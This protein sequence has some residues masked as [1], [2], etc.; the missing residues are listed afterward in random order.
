MGMKTGSLFSGILGAEVAAD[1]VDGLRGVW[2]SEIEPWCC[3]VIANRRPDLPNLGDVREINGRRIEP[4]DVVTFGSPCQDLSVAGRRAGLD[5]ARSS[6][7]FE[8]ARVI[9]QCRPAFAIWENVPGAFSSN[10]GRDFWSVLYTLRELGANDVAWR[11]YDSQYAGVPQQRRRIYLVAD[12]RG[13]RAGEVLFDANRCGGHPA[14]LPAPGQGVAGTLTSGTSRLGVNR[15]GRRREDDYNLTL[16]DVE[17]GGRWLP[18]EGTPDL[19]KPLGSNATGGFR[20]DLDHDTYVVAPAVTSKWAKG[21]GG[22]ADDETQNLTLIQDVRG[23]AHKRQNGAGIREGETAYT[24]DTVS[25]QAVAFEPRHFTRGKA[26]PPADLV[27]ALT[28]DADRGDG[29]PLV[30]ESRFARNGRGAPRE[31]VPTLK[32]ESGQTGRGDGAALMQHHGTIRRFTPVECEMLQGFPPGWTCLCG[33]GADMFACR[34]PDGP[35]YRAVGNAMTT[36]P[37]SPMADILRAM[38]KFF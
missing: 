18:G 30:F 38:R 26:G 23:G 36:G 17:M 5:G 28:A 1:S 3:R 29:Q 9:N 4:V 20:F 2:A 27:P 10:A 33:A 21:S 11:V 14:P 25:Q 8:A 32:A 19:A 15:P 12:F 6:L 31:I 35:R 24:V 13:R 34:C 16:A 7:F 22:P 37:E